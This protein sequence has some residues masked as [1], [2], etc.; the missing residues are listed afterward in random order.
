MLHKK[1]MED[2]KASGSKEETREMQKSPDHLSEDEWDFQKLMEII[3][4]QDDE[5]RR[6]LKAN[7]RKYIDNPIMSQGNEIFKE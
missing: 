4:L 7:T 1:H 2:S 6:V 5:D 3:H